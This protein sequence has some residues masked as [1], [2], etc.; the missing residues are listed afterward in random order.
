MLEPRDLPLL[1][2]FTTV[3][4]RGS[5]TAAAKELKVSKS[6]VSDQVRVLEARLG[7]RLL[8]RSTRSLHP[9]Q[10][11]AAVLTAAGAI[12]QAVG[13]IAA[14]LEDHRDAPVGTL[15]VAATNDLAARFVAPVAGRLAARHPQLRIDVVSSD[16]TQDLIA[17]Q[18]DV[19]VRLGVPRDSAAVMRKLATLPEIIVGAPA[20][21]GSRPPVAAPQDLA[22]APWV[23]HSLLGLN[24]VLTLHGPSKEPATIAVVPRA[25]ANSAEVVR[26]LILAGAGFGCLPGYLVSEDLRRG[27]LQRLCPGWVSRHI[28]LF[29]ILP[30]TRPPKRVALFLAGLK[31]ALALEGL[32]KAAQ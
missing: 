18:L 3:V 16:A 22:G 2:V 24:D 31:E 21:V 15:R 11:G 30:S 27:A 23:H 25:Q 17:G 12:T 20:L 9:T 28:T 8:E 14:V 7:L 5:F 6:V 1:V 32:Q 10:V 4:R 13:E 19:G 26:G 29:A